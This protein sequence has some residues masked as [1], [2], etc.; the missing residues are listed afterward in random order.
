MEDISLVVGLKFFWAF[1]A[2]TLIHAFIEAVASRN[3][4]AELKQN[5][6]KSYWCEYG[7]KRYDLVET[8]VT[9]GTET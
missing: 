6:D 5:S 8:P 9:K 2:G 1:I 4:S 7:G 3:N